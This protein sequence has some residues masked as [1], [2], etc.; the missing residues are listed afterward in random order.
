MDGSN[1]ARN[2]LSPG[3]I[4]QKPRQ[5]EMLSARILIAATFAFLLI[6]PSCDGR[7][8][9]GLSPSKVDSAKVTKSAAGGQSDSTSDRCILINGQIY[10]N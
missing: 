8:P 9:T 2:T 3:G 7:T 1:P 6:L 10:C 5:R 4:M